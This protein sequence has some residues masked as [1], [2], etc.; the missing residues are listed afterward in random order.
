MAYDGYLLKLGSYKV[1]TDKYIK[2]DSYQ[3]HVV[4][5][6]IDDWTDGFG[7]LH[8]NVVELKSLK[9]EFETPQGLTNTEFEAFMSKIRSNYKSSKKQEIMVKAFV[10]QLNTYVEQRCYMANI[11][12]QIYS[13]WNVE[14]TYNSVKF[15]FVGGLADD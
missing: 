14:L 12:P 4:M 8:R 10:P 13:E 5:Q 11:Q 7:K 3:P 9:V 6:D 2:M 15:S 1:D